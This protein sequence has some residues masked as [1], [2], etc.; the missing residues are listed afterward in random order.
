VSVSVRGGECDSYL[1]LRSI[2]R[3]MSKSKVTVIAVTP[4][5]TVCPYRKSELLFPF[6]QA[7]R[8]L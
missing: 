6:M 3:G 4:T 8:R 1:R 5:P 2:A 7:G